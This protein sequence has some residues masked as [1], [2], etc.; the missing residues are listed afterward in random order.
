MTNETTTAPE[1]NNRALVGMILIA[2]G[3][4]MLLGYIVDTGLL[5]LPLLA[6]IFTIA[7]IRSRSSG[8][9]IPAGILGG[10]GL[11]AALIETL[12]LTE[13]IAG[14]VFLVSFAAGWALIPLL[15]AIFT[16]ERVWWPFIPGGVM[17]VI[18]SLLLVGE[19]GSTLLDLI[20][21]QA[22]W[23]WPL[24]LIAIGVAL[25]FRRERD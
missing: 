22:G 14:G 25:L 16:G 1:Q 24:A 10:I 19:L 21:D 11:G 15:S 18:G 3:A 7:G 23:I 2:V 17:A 12:P 6:L 20:F 9:F 5:V 4:I 8:W 13:D